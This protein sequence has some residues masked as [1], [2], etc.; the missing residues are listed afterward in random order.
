MCSN[1]RFYS[2]KCSDMTHRK[3]LHLCPL[4]PVINVA[5]SLCHMPAFISSE[6]YLIS[7]ETLTTWIK[8]RR[9]SVRFKSN[10]EK[11]AC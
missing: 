1:A 3:Q 2:W 11:H 6:F 5:L 4:Q 8:K 9:L 10:N 7:P